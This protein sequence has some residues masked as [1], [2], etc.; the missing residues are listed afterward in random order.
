MQE[1]IRLLEFVAISQ[2]PEVLAEVLPLEHCDW[3]VGELRP[4][5]AGAERRRAARS[6]PA[7]AVVAADFARVSGYSPLRSASSC[8]PFR[9]FIIE[10]GGTTIT[11]CQT[12]SEPG[13]CHC[14]HGTASSGTSRVSPSKKGSPRASRK[15]LTQ[16][17]ISVSKEH[18][19]IGN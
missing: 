19:I 7:L 11:Q 18:E 2:F 15:S 3:P 5:R 14:V 1:I 6:W 13:Q 9:F 10:D 16:F 4:A 17:A 8:N 12:V